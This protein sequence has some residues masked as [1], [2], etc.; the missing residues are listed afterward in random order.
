MANVPMALP[1]P[2]GRGDRRFGSS[3]VLY[4]IRFC[5]T[6][7]RDAIARPGRSAVYTSAERPRADPFLDA[8]RD[9]RSEELSA[10]R[11]ARPGEA[12]SSHQW[13]CLRR[14]P[15]QRDEPR[16][17]PSSAY[18]Q[19]EKIVP[20]NPAVR[21]SLSTAGASGW[22]KS[23]RELAA[24]EAGGYWRDV[25]LTGQP[26]SATSGRGECRSWS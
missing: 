23:G 6:T 25:V 26:R 21:C 15:E 16:R 7:T 3:A 9:S 4:R 18:G 8:D 17:G 2:S 12:A 19:G 5:G 24:F 1:S 14:S 10:R 20:G 13:C 22:S 11:N